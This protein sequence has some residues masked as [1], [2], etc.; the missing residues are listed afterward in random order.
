MKVLSLI[1]EYNPFH[2][3]HIYHIE[4]SKQ[5]IQP[6][7]TIAIMSGNFTQRGELAVTNKFNRAQEAIKHVDLVVELPT[8]Y[9]ISYADDFAYGGLMAAKML[10][11]TDIVFGSELDD[12][13]KLHSAYLKAKR[14]TK[15]DLAPLFKKGYSYPRAMYDLTNEDAFQS[16]NNTLGMSYLK[17]RDD[18][19]FDVSM[20][21]IKRTGNNYNDKTL[22]HSQFSSATSIR[23]SLLN[24][25]IEDA[26][27][28]MPETLAKVIMEDKVVTNEHMFNTLKVIIERSS[29]KDLKNIYMMTEGLEHRLKKNIRLSNN[30]ESFID[31]IKTKRYTRTRL[32]RLL[33]Y[34]LLNV[35]EEDFRNYEVDKLRVLAMNHTG[36][37]YLSTI[38]D[39]RFIT[40]LTKKDAPDFYE[41]IKATHIYNTLTQG[42]VNDFNQPV[43]I[44]KS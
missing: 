32:Q 2:N 29:L 40:N 19:N 11:T 43:M 16:P 23:E 9:A 34:V 36:Q 25:D 21:T 5:L 26:I 13:E 4:S 33:L 24:G 30:Y 27:Q 14:I 18:L 17:A 12:I 37:Q 28:F 42:C 6:D 3:G 1:T 10:Q 22:S 15:E 7:V 35:T 20:H 8:L 41:T 31:S 44:L 39:G 38:Q